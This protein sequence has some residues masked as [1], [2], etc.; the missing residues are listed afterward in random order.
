VIRTSSGVPT[1]NLYTD[2]ATG[3][4]KERRIK[5]VVSKG[6]D[7]GIDRVVES[8]THIVGT[9]PNC[10]V[11]LTDPTV[12]RYHLELQ[13]LADGVKVTD[14]QSTNG[15]M[16]GGTKL[17]TVVVT[18]PA[19]L[20]LGKNTEIDL[21]PADEEVTLPPYAG[22]RFGNVLGASAPM[23][24]LFAVLQRVAPTEA[25]VLIEGETGTGK[26]VIA[27]AIHKQSSRA[28]KP[29]V[30]VDCGAIP[31][32]IIASELFGHVRGAFTGAVNP[33]EGLVEAADGG[34][35]FLDE[36]GELALDL[37]PQLLRVL[38][39]RE[40]RKVGDVKAQKVDIRV[41]AAT[42]R[43]LRKMVKDGTFRE[44]LY[45]RLAVVRATVPPLRERRD[46]IRVLAHAFAEQMGRGGFALPERLEQQLV[47]YDWPGNVRELRNVVEQALSLG[48]GVMS[49]MAHGGGAVA[50]V[51]AGPLGGGGVGGGGAPGITA[52]DVLDLP[53]KEA[54]G[55]LVEEFER[56]YLTA[57]L[58]RHKGNVS[59]AAQEAGIDR[60]YIHRLVKKY[61]IPV[62]R[63]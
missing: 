30:V 42:N 26:E 16:H 7:A 38:E 58:A 10:D 41:I 4:L 5:L 60:N 6:P 35:L 1:A 15:T 22:D 40:V 20:R 39:K 25:T 63:D 49:S 14:L 31:R 46:D 21:V 43:D 17:G 50:A 37:Q 36:I 47:A 24:A 9:H 32:E 48:D 33:K 53:F 28:E 11:R 45:F 52:Q 56:E 51:T 19:R 59:R 44:D 13:L 62:N 8:G 29:F 61:G 27:E 3:A 2:A 34:T 57:L 54:K 55:R 18:G 23:R 12:S